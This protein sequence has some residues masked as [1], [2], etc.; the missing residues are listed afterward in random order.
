M[1]KAGELY[2]A[3]MLPPYI[4]Q[5]KLLQHGLVPRKQLSAAGHS[6]QHVR[7]ETR[8]GGRSHHRSP[9][10]PPWCTVPPVLFGG[11]ADGVRQCGATPVVPL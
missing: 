4:A 5:G 11:G 6:R 7:E 1:A 2:I 8:E 9:G 3:H 10:W